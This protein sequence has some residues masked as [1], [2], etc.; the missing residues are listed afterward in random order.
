MITSLAYRCCRLHP[1]IRRTSVGGIARYGYQNAYI[2]ELRT[3][4]RLSD[5]V[6]GA[7]QERIRLSER[8]KAGLERARKQGKV[9]GRPKAAV[10]AMRSVRSVLAAGALSGETPSWLGRPVRKL[11]RFDGAFISFEKLTH[12]N[13]KS[14]GQFD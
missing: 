9:L 8:T 10:N 4:W 13:P 14:I 3:G 2:S 5:G 11:A 1:L 6:I 12:G 7:K